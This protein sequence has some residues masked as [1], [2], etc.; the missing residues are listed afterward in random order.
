[1]VADI[2]HIDGL[3]EEFSF[4]QVADAINTEDIPP[5]VKVRYAFPSVVF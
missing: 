4:Q 2:V 5:H 3:A 1:V